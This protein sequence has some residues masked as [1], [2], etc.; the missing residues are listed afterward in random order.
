MA[1]DRMANE[2][3]SRQF[4][5][6]LALTARDRRLHSMIGASFI[7]PTAGTNGDVGRAHGSSAGASN[8]SDL[9]DAE[10]TLYQHGLRVAEFLAAEFG[11]ESLHQ[12]EFLAELA[13]EIASRIADEMPP[14][15]AAQPR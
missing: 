13:G 14:A 15:A 8:A 1:A 3:V 10:R 9:S 12:R 4:P 6:R 2:L 7:R 5:D 11:A